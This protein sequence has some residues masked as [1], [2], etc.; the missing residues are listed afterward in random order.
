MRP[1]KLG[2]LGIKDLEKFGRALWLRWLWHNWDHNDRPL[3]QLLQITDDTDRQLFF[4]STI[5][6]VGDGKNTPFREARW[7]DGSAPKEFAPNLFKLARFKKRNVHTEM[8]NLHWIRNL[9]NIDSP[10]LLDE[11]ILLFMALESVVLNQQKDEIKWR[12]STDG[13]YSIASTY[14]CQFSGSFVWFQQFQFGRPRL[15]QNVIFLPG[16]LCM[17]KIITVDNTIRRNW[18]ATITVL[19]TFAF[20]R[21]LNTSLHLAITLKLHGI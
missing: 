6:I 19:S 8:Q 18:D 7:I 15:N 3:K 10:I 9:S 4:A 14:E 12:W 21:H 13:I 1:K 16:L 17:V 20:M 2:G 5:I 11:F